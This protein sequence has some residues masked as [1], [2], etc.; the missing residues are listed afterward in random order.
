MSVSV[1]IAI[2]A[3]TT[4][5]AAPHIWLVM[6]ATRSA[7]AAMFAGTALAAAARGFGL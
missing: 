1:L 6:A 3:P 7:L 2:I 4:W 5:R